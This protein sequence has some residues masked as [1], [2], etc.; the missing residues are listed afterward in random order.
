MAQPFRWDRG[1]G[2][3]LPYRTRANY[4]PVEDGASELFW[5]RVVER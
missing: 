3:G 4:T 1:E 5:R 2:L